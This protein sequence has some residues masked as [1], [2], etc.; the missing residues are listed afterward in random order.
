[1]HRLILN[2]QE[3]EGKEKDLED[4]AISIFPEEFVAKR[5]L[6]IVEMPSPAHRLNEGKVL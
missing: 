2:Q 3:D 1:M 4:S 6:K 5:S